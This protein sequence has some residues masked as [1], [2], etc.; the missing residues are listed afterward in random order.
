MTN[1]EF[2]NHLK[3]LKE[4]DR[5]YKHIYSEHQPV[6]GNPGFRFTG[7]HHY[8]RFDSVEGWQQF[9]RGTGWKNVSE[10]CA[11]V[12]RCRIHFGLP[13]YQPTPEEES[14]YNEQYERIT[15][16]MTQEKATSEKITSD[17]EAV[18]NLRPIPATLE[19]IRT[20]LKHF[21]QNGTN[22]LPAM[23]VGYSCNEY[24]C[25]GKAAIAVILEQPVEGYTKLQYGAPHGYLSNYTHID[26]AI[27]SREN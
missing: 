23:T 2:Y 1:Q 16:R 5:K 12:I 25:D 13:K 26:R 22:E 15:A 21:L 9:G 4:N 20:I 24:D 18:K 8:I 6:H 3:T 10:L 14:R 19:N 27:L 11:A 17:W 7:E